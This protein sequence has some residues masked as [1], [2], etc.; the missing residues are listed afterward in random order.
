M[1]VKT[2]LVKEIEMSELAQMNIHLEN[3]NRQDK[4]SGRYQ[5]FPR[6]KLADERN[7]EISLI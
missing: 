3:R 6:N 1:N 4:N 5:K 2:S 7:W